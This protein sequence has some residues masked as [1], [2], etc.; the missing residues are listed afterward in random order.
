MRHFRKFVCELGALGPATSQCQRPPTERPK[1]KPGAFPA[2][3]ANSMLPLR[4]RQHDRYQVGGM[5]RSRGAYGCICAEVRRGLLVAQR[6]DSER[7][8][9]REVC[10][11][12]MTC[13]PKKKKT[14]IAGHAV[15]E[16][17]FQANYKAEAS[18]SNF[19]D[20][21][22]GN[23]NML[24]M[25]IVNHLL[26]NI[27]K[28]RR[29]DPPAFMHTEWHSA[30]L[31]LLPRSSASLISSDV[32]RK[33][34]SCKTERVSTAALL[35]PIHDPS[36]VSLAMLDNHSTQAELCKCKRLRDS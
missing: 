7:G 21:A 29:T 10:T 24:R 18:G 31:Y 34:L 6:R 23:P 14:I 28:D 3:R 8:Q 5:H 32:P 12:E 25:P 17:L 13:N 22:P 2:N 4:G 36:H 30:R 16:P 27:W 11:S 1:G 26:P 15:R 9:L 19:W 20:R 35:R 33:I